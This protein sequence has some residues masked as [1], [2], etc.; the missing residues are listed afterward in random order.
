ME[1]YYLIFQVLFRNLPQIKDEDNSTFLP[2]QAKCNSTS[3]FFPELLVEI[4]SGFNYLE[5]SFINLQNMIPQRLWA[6]KDA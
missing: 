2:Q 1:V 5:I 4:K 3:K 6:T